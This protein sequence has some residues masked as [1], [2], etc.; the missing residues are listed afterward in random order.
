[1]NSS[2]SSRSTI[3]RL[4]LISSLL[5]AAHAHAGIVTDAHGNTGYTT[6]SECDA[7][8][9]AGTAK[10]Y[11]SFTHQPQ[12]KHA[13][14]ADVKVMRLGELDGY[15]KG[16]CDL[17]VGHRN[18][19]D[20]VSATLV[21][22]YVPF[23]PEMSV[24]AYLD[25]QGKVVRATMQQCDNNFNGEMPRPVGVQVAS[26]ECYATVLTPAKFETRTEQVVKVA[27][28]KRFEPVPPAFKTVT[29]EVIV[30][31]E[32]KR[33]IPVPA[34]YKEVSEQVLV[35]PESFREEPIPATYKMVAEKLMVSPESKRIEVLPGTFK[36]VSEK[37]MV[38]PERKELKVIP[39]TYT[40]KEESVVDRPATTR[41]ETVPASFKTETERVLLKAESVRYEPI[42]LPLRTVKE[43][44]LRS[45]ASSKLHAT[46]SAV[47]TETEQ[48]VV[49]EA[50]KRLIEVPAVYETV[51]ERIKIADATK[52]WKRGKAWVGKAL[53]VRPLRG[54]VVDKDGKVDGASVDT[55]G[56]VAD[57]TRLDDDV[58]C[59]VE[60]PAQYQMISRQVLKTPATVREEIIPAQYGTVKRQVLAK[61]AA[62]SETDIPATY[63]TVT[64]QVIDVEK[65]KS[66]GY[67]FDATGDIVA[68]PGGERVLRAA[69]VA[70][71]TKADKS[72]GAQSGHEGYVREINIPAQYQTI[73][74]QVVD[75]PA[76]VRT[77]EVPATFKTVKTRV[78]ETAASTEEMGIPAVYE[79]VTREV[80]DK[81]PSSREIVIP[82][83][84]R[85]VERKV[86]D[87]PASTRK[88]PV[89]A[90]FDTVKRRVIDQP[91]SFREEVIP[92][93]TQVVSRQ[94]VDRPA[95]V[96]EIVVPAQYETLSHQVK[97][98]EGKTEQRAILCETNAT[99]RKIEEIQRALKKAGFEPGP[100]DGHL[101]AQTLNAVNRYQQANNLPADGFLNLETVKALGVSPN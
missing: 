41:V 79:T 65:L 36:A 68:T 11:Q 40:D 35:R 83:V 52:E 92:A 30:R 56:D 29:E 97:V 31:P 44:V 87:Q 45:E 24:N 51:T 53:H 12:L 3:W 14:E 20:G 50:S 2:L 59:L 91:A 15:A 63:Q 96:R 13:G 7:A 74:R 43:E 48:V 6:A 66:M 72:A 38:S 93:V 32:M 1:M 8:V 70:G 25:A 85:T 9:N 88:I 95:S 17:G 73:S 49:K 81:A 39:A 76:T 55:Q 58:M 57:N 64:H 33:Q 71:A 78:V 77:V 60:I 4:S 90:L 89:P 54:F 42:V 23:S 84:Y 98:A 19:R 34:T 82:A 61:E 86:V 37:V 10:F 75:Q 22:K 27:E 80:I 101:R 94:V 5:L 46:K 28:T 100:I 99:P 69:S 47:K 67:K 21:G 26:S 16:A 18:N 62:T